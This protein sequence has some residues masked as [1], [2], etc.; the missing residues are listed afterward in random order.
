MKKLG[1]HKS[2]ET[3]F[4]T[5]E[6]NS[7]K[8]LNVSI[9]LSVI[10]A[11]LAGIHRL[12][13]ITHMSSDPLVSKLLGLQ[14]PLNKDVIGSRLK[15]FGQSGALALH[16]Y[17]QDM[18]HDFLSHGH[19]KK[20]TLDVDST[21][22]SVYGK[23]EGS[24]KGYN[25]VK[26]G[27][28]SYHNLIGFISDFKLV[29]N[30]WFRDGTSYT[31]NGICEFV[32][33]IHARLPSS[34]ENV[35]FRADSGF[36]QEEL[37]ALLEEWGWH[38]LVKVKLKNLETILEKQRWRK[39]QD[40]NEYCTFK[41]GCGTWKKE[42]RFCGVRKKDGFEEIM[43][44]GK[45]EKVPSYTYSCFCTSYKK[46]AA[47]IYQ[48]Y[49]ERSTSE[50]W[51]EEVKSQ[52]KAGRTMTQNF[53]ANEILWILA[54]MAYNI[55]NMARLKLKLKGGMEHK[56]FKV[57]FVIVLGKV[58]NNGGR[59]VLKVSRKYGYYEEWIHLDQKLE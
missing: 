15:S 12:T 1:I 42:R 37:F 44:N 59:T 53:F 25:P 24:G 34:V 40:G 14:S 49:R 5:S 23:Q 39:G 30:S 19:H 33:E 58:V 41:Y 13:H 52:A 2:L 46:W 3:L 48:L 22:Q 7:L 4:P 17:F 43:V 8:H 20:I 32:K 10:F 57:K 54:I 9:L 11:S 18:V 31:S 50:T 56:T 26:K 47:T 35:F 28:R 16:G 27:C 21:V 38:Y 51:I 6:Y 45:K 29:V 36:F 55:G